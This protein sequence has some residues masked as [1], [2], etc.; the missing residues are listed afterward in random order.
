MAAH[1]SR[2]ANC[3][4]TTATSGGSGTYLLLAVAAEQD[5][6]H[7]QQDDAQAH[8]E[9]GEVGHDRDNHEQRSH[10]GR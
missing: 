10:L 9:Q 7:H 8:N 3:A 1:T 5:N 2:Q 6:Q 4:L